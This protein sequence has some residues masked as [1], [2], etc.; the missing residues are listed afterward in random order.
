MLNSY[1]LPIAE[2]G[3]LASVVSPEPGSVLWTIITFLLIFWLVKKFGWT[4]ILTGLK[5][6]EDTIRKDLEFARSER[7]KAHSMLADYQSTIAGARKEAAD[8]IN[9]A[10]ESANQL[11]EQERMRA[12]ELA[13]RTI[14]R[15]TQEI[16]RERDQARS[17]LR[18]YVADLTAR[19]TTKLLGR[20]IDAKEHERLIMDALKEEA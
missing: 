4:P 19:A 13:D 1:L 7:E 15:A 3:G 17:D 14:A 20:T 12:K 5:S 2:G 8:I 6:R 10:Q 11:L 9:K 16:E 18:S